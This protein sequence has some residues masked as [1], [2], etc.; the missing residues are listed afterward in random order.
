VPALVLGIGEA[1]GLEIFAAWSM[2]AMTAL[3]VTLAFRG[4]GLSRPEG[5][6]IIALYGAFV[7]TVVAR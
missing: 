5:V 1:S 7:L 3:A 2:V 6:A 4:G